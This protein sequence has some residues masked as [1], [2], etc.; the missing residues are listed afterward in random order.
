[1]SHLVVVAAGTGGHVMPGLAVA[2]A[3]R[4]RG[5]SVS[6]L[7]TRTGM[8]RGLVERQG[9][10]FDAIDFSGLRG[11]GLKT[12][13]FGGFLLLRAIWQSRTRLRARSP[14]AVFSTGAM[15]RCRPA[16]LP[17]RWGCR[18]C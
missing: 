10:D 17:A 1:V 16:W 9:I 4:G 18:W 13:L 6:W 5:W 2:E 14:K 11:K 3:L 8:E 12:M 15:S 7:G